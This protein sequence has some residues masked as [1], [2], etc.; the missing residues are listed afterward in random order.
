MSDR[1]GP[2]G[3]AHRPSP[4]RRRRCRPVADLTVPLPSTRGRE[5]TGSVPG[6]TGARREPTVADRTRMAAG[7]DRRRVT[8]R[9]VLET[10]P[11]SQGVARP[12]R[13]GTKAI[14]GERA[15]P[16]EARAGAWPPRTRR[17]EGWASGGVG[18]TQTGSRDAGRS[19]VKAPASRWDRSAGRTARVSYSG[20]Q[21]IGGEDPEATPRCSSRSRGSFPQ[22]GAASR[23]G[24]APAW[25]GGDAR[26]PERPGRR[27][28]EGGPDRSGP[29]TV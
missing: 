6:G 4:G 8:G 12:C 26:V 11:G 10:T 18:P 16:D 23:T 17:P 25:I 27:S 1:L 14:G 24:R 29:T 5:H 3:V 22:C 9:V 19:D 2:H 7:I 15:G 28:H 13:T 20:V 21:F